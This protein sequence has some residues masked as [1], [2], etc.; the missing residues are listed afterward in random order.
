[1]FFLKNDSSPP[2][3]EKDGGRGGIS[4]KCPILDSP[5]PP[6]G[7]VLIQKLPLGQA[8]CRRE[9]KLFIICTRKLLKTDVAHAPAIDLTLVAMFKNPIHQCIQCIYFSG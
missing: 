5:L 6:F 7:I 9:E 8:L 2:Q 1:V 3:K 4:P